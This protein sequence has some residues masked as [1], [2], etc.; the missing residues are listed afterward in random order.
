M[1]GKHTQ[2]VRQN[3]ALLARALNLPEEQVELIRQAAPLHDVGKIGIPDHV[4]LKPGR[5]TAEE[6]EQMKSHATI[7]AGTLSGSRFPLLQ[8]AEE[9]AITHHER[10]DGTGYPRALKEEEIPLVGRI[11]AIA[12]VF[13]ALTHERPYKEAWTEEEAIAELERQKGRQFDPRVVEAFL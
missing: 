5:L 9:I 1:T 11:V 13:D 3:S 10:W 8:L 6:F 2:R 4:L 12:D 7:G